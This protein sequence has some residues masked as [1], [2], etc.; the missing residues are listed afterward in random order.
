MERDELLE[1]KGIIQ[2]VGFRIKVVA[3]LR[4]FLSWLESHFQQ[5]LKYGHL[6]PSPFAYNLSSV[7]DSDLNFLRRLDRLGQVFGESNLMVR[8][9]RSSELTNGCVVRDFCA[10]VGIKQNSTIHSYINEGFSI[11]AVRLLY[12]LAKYGRNP[13]LSRLWK[14]NALI[15]R[16]KLLPGNKLRFHPSIISPIQGFLDHQ[17]NQILQ[18]YGV[19]L[20]VVPSS[21]SLFADAISCEDDLFSY[22]VASLE[23]LEA[24]TKARP[25]QGQGEQAARQVATAMDHL[26]RLVARND[27]QQFLRERLGMTM[28]RLLR[29]R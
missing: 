4:P 14:A 17:R 8:S 9:Y 27:W 28:R 12:A 22:S 21:Q 29:S 6:P 1:L 19:D 2:D 3:Y 11:N 24:Q 16:L 5:R 25:I 10:L 18:R 15:R 26:Q 23:W 13:M 7:E 20:G